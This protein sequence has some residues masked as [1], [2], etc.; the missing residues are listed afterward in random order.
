MAKIS[1]LVAFLTI[2]IGSLQS[3]AAETLGEFP[4]SNTLWIPITLNLEIDEIRLKFGA[5]HLRQNAF[6][7]LAIT[8]IAETSYQSK[9]DC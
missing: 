8:E 5:P 3:V 2:T 6:G 1:Q 4:A 9:K 7:N